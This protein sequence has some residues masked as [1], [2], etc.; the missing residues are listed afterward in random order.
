MEDKKRLSLALLAVTAIAPITW[1]STYYVTATHL[2]EDRPLFAALVRALPFGLALLLVRRQLPKGDWWWRSAVL[3]VVNVGAFFALIFVAAYR[4]PGG[5]AATLTATTP[6]VVAVLAWVL[7]KERPTTHVLAGAALGVVGV[8]LLVLRAGFT[9]DPVGVA[10]SLSAVLLFSLG[11][12]LVKRWRPP[13][14]MLTFTSWQLVAGGL[15]I[16]P[17]ALVVEGGPPAVD[18]EAVAGYLYIGVV[19]TVVAYTVWFIGIGRLPATAVA[20]VGLL[21]PVSGTAIGVALAGERFGPVQAAGTAL[22]IAGIAWGTTG[23][24]SR[25]V[26]TNSR[27]EPEAI[28]GRR[29]PRG[30]NTQLEGYEH[31]TRRGRTP[32]STSAGELVGRSQADRRQLERGQPAHDLGVLGSPRGGRVVADRGQ[33]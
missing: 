29:A 25:R 8:A 22:V 7:V 14:D 21:N 9:V 32:N 2:P 3:G 5:L 28:L 19:G 10:A 27:S 4:L 18:A 6:F 1:G 33:A 12:V 31:P 11:I 17:V 24:R 30:T 20:L 13:V 16:A 23:G 26:S 15:A